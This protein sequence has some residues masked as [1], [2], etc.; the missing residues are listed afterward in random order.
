LSTN[1]RQKGHRPQTTVGVKNWCG[2]KNICSDMLG[3]VTKHACDRR[4]D[5]ET[6]R[7]TTANTV[8]AWSRPMY[9]H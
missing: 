4:T 5:R 1:F 9:Y 6:D 8:L 7:I 2:I 3:F